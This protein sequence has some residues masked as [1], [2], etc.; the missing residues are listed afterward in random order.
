L[1]MNT[2]PTV[3]IVI[4]TYNCDKKKKKCLSRIRQQDYPK[5]KIEVLVVDGGS[6][7][8]TLK[9]AKSFGA[10]VIHGGFSNNSEPRRA[11]GLLQA[12][13][14]I[15]AYIDS[16]IFLPTPHWLREMVT[17]LMENPLIVAT[18]P[19]RYEYR[20]SDSLLNRYFTLIG[21]HDSIAYYFNKR[22]RFSWRENKW[23][24]YGKAQDVGRYYLV[25]FNLKKLP[26]LGCN[27]FVTRRDEMLKLCLPDPEKLPF[28]THSDAVYDMVAQGRDTLGFVKNTVIHVPSND[29]FWQYLKKRMFYTALLHFRNQPRRY[30]V[31]N[32]KSL[33]DNFNLAKYIL[34]SLTLVKPLYD[35]VSGFLRLRD[36]AWFIHP[37]MCPAMLFAYGTVTMRQLLRTFLLRR[38]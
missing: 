15:I 7:D 36:V 27:G 13:N 21:C 37:V 22:D 18:Q 30:K 20:R 12:E 19:L 8:N 3:S 31:Y 35:S 38:R 14:E 23:N 24:L 4:V 9:A 26:P 29:T 32:P 17:P 1:N 28:F 6:T 34:Y 25:K 16:D 2:L 10:K 5:E 11:I 33:R